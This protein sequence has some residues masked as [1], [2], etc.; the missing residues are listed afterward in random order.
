[1]K[2]QKIIQFAAKKRRVKLRRLV[3]HPLVDEAM[4]RLPKGWTMK[5]YIERGFFYCY[6]ERPDRTVF[7]ADM[8]M[9]LSVDEQLRLLIDSLPNNAVTGSEARP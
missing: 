3:G 4:K 9:R 6:I 1:M 2:E 8:H 7:N 5:L